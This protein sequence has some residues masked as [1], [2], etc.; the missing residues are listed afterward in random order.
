MPSSGLHLPVDAPAS[1][2]MSGRGQPRGSLPPPFC[3][4]MLPGQ[5][6]R[7]RRDSRPQRASPCRRDTG[8]CRRDFGFFDIS[9][10]TPA[11]MALLCPAVVA[12]ED[13]QR[14]AANSLSCRARRRLGRSRR[15]GTRPSRH[16]CGGSGQRCSCTGP[17]I[18]GGL[19]R[20]VRRVERQVEV[21]RSAWVLSVDSFRPRPL[22]MSRVV[23]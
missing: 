20:R 11:N 14:V 10:M 17:C 7:R 13:D 22:P 23:V 15:P 18:L 8:R 6:A 9:A 2:R 12:M 19:V 3:A 21:K 16:R 1:A 5:L 4:L